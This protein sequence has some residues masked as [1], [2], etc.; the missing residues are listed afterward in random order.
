MK[1]DDEAPLLITHK[2]CDRQ[3]MG[4]AVN[5]M[6]SCLTNLI[7]HFPKLAGLHPHL[8]RYDWNHRFSIQA[9]AEGLS[10]TEEKEA[11]RYLMGWADKS[12][13]A[14]LYNYR[15]IQERGMEIGLK[16]AND[17]SRDRNK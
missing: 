5:T 13:M 1:F 10:E 17:T 14:N 4:V 2:K 12:D 15:R 8:I 3:G 16:V 7:V 11:R 9:E 6:R